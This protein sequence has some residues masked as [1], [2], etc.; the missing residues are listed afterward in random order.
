V[1]SIFFPRAILPV[2]TVLFNFAQYLLTALVLLPLILAMYHVPLS[3]P[4]LLYPVILA[5]QLAFTIG[6]AL[7]LATGTAFFRDI[8]HFLDVALAALFWLTPIVY[9][10]DDIPEAARLPILLTPMSPYI[11]AY[12][13]I[14]YF[15]RWPEP[16]VWLLATLYAAAA[17][18]VG[19][20]VMLANEDRFSE[21]I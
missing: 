14:F 16:R 21:Q 7:I 15:G 4:M 12:H 19:A 13:D 18:T 1:K 20:A 9:K 2:A 17:L 3:A 10:L 6:V 5:L 8:R 11:V